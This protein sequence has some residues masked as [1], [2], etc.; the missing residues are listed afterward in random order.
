MARKKT[1]YSWSEIKKAPEGS[2]FVPKDKIYSGA[3]FARLGNL[4]YWCYGVGGCE[5]ADGSWTKEKFLKLPEVA[6]V[7][8]VK[9]TPEVKS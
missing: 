5:P 1:V 2:V 6:T 8:Q 3:K 9:F 7:A 4:L